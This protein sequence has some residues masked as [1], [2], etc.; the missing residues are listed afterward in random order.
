MF[1]LK[2]MHGNVYLVTF[3]C[4][5]LFCRH[6]FI[7]RLSSLFLVPLAMR[8]LCFLDFVCV[9]MDLFLLLRF[10]QQALYL[11]FAPEVLT[12]VLCP[13][14]Q[15][16]HASLLLSLQRVWPIQRHFLRLLSDKPDKK[17]FLKAK[18]CSNSALKSINCT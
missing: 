9:S 14:L 18:K 17:C 8:A 4:L 3:S 6:S 1:F 13:T 5:A 7:Y 16:T 2:E 12:W 11:S 10:L 15:C